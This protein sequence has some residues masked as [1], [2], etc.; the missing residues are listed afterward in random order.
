[1]TTETPRLTRWMLLAALALAACNGGTQDFCTHS[2][3]ISQ[4]LEGEVLMC[5][6]DAGLPP[7]ANTSTQIAKCQQ[8]LTGCNAQDQMTLNTAANCIDALPAIQCAWFTSDGGVPLS[9][10]AWLFDLASCE[11]G[12][13]SATCQIATGISLDAGFPF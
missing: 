3:A 12:S 9:A 2:V 8:E 13:L 1:M 6:L 4:K 7:L 5:A 11:P 10:L